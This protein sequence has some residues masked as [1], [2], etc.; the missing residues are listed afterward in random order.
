MHD[1]FLKTHNISNIAD[2]LMLRAQNQPDKTAFIFLSGGK[3]SEVKITY[4]EL[5]TQARAIAAELQEKLNPGDRA[6][7]LYPPGLE[8]MSAF[9]GC[10]YAGIIAVPCYPPDPRKLDVSMARLFGIISDCTPKIIITTKELLD[11]ASFI[12]PDYPDLEGLDWLSVDQVD[13]SLKDKWRKRTIGR[14][15]TAF[16]QYTSGST[17]APKGVI[18]SHGNLLHNS[19][20]IKQAFEST[21]NALGVTWLPMYHDMGLI[22]HVLQPLYLGIH[23]IFMSPV[24]FLKNPLH[25]L[26][27]VSRYKATTSGAPNFAYEL[28]V[29]KI[30]PEEMAGL[31]LGSWQL[32]F[33]G[34]EPIRAATLNRFAEK[35]KVCGFNP[36]ALYPCYGLAEATL[37]VSGG[38]KNAPLRIEYIDRNAL[39]QNRVVFCDSV[40]ESAISL[41]SSGKSWLEQKIVIVQP[42]L[43]TE[44][45]PGMIGEIWVSGDSVAQGYWKKTQLSCDTF[46]ACLANTGE[47]PFLRTGDLGFMKDGELFITGRLKDLLVIRGRNYYPQDIEL[48]VEKSHPDLRPGCTAAFSVEIENEEKLTVV[49]EIRRDRAEDADV[50]DP[51]KSIRTAVAYRHDLQVYAAVLIEAGSIPKT[52]SGKI[53]RQRCKELFLEDGLKTVTDW[54][55]GIL[56]NDAG[57]YL[58]DGPVTLESLQTLTVSLVSRLSGI[59]AGEI[60]IR[61]PFSSYGLDSMKL[62]DLSAE[63][64]KSLNKSHPDAPC[65][66][67][68]SAA[69]EFQ[70]V[71]ALS[72]YLLRMISPAIE[73]DP[74]SSA[75][76]LLVLKNEGDKDPIFFVHSIMGNIFQMKNLI[77]EFVE[78]GHPLYGIHACGLDSEA[79]L[80]GSMAEAAAGYIDLID[81]ATDR[82]PIVIG[83][84]FGGAVAYEIVRQLESRSR[85]GLAVLIDI[86]A[87]QDGL[88]V[89]E[90]DEAKVFLS[91][92]SILS[93]FLGINIFLEYCRIRGLD[94]YR[95]KNLRIIREDV[96]SISEKE[97]LETFMKILPVVPIPSQSEY[98]KNPEYIKRMFY[99]FKNNVFRMGVGYRPLKY[100]GETLVITAEDGS[101]RAEISEFGWKREY[102]MNQREA[103]AELLKNPAFGWEKYCVAVKTDTSPGDHN[104]ML[105]PPNSKVLA[106]KIKSWIRATPKADNSVRQNS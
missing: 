15:A 47:G 86:P 48:T 31:D 70:T 80:P 92:I 16:L 61:E 28:C 60:N 53:Q 6:L 84:C 94:Y 75:S 41:V 81:N 59:P 67:S 39:E 22:G 37:A 36:K 71:E 78:E 91:F 96:E 68:A 19:E 30:S 103:I 73:S 38:L 50:N 85:R 101:H 93:S 82:P 34:A 18:L 104:G 35:F 42:E 77:M 45:P 65:S 55:L 13:L 3:E 69:L 98:Q 95:D 25:W 83:H 40:D 54:K 63:L 2:L 66:F 97:R 23:S 58:Q 90:Q 33:C 20:I 99:V 106:G 27:T 49:Q 56:E 105:Q 14:K 46:Q 64:E 12:F 100:G 52:S 7:M 5:D 57:F 17:G 9:F 51:L 74:P 102:D 11:L 79:E 88:S 89:F 87:P 76:S 10:M 26:R 1:N 21:E 4:R 24:D 72:E 44:C 29:N 62:V 8:F 32:A 43:S